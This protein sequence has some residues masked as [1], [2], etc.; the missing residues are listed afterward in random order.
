MGTSADISGGQSR[1]QDE[2]GLAFEMVT[3]QS[4][5]PLRLDSGEDLYP[6]VQAYNTYGSLNAD[7]TNA[8]LV[9]HA[10]TLDQHAA[11][12][13]PATGKE[14]WWQGMIGPGRPID[15]DRFFVICPNV[16]GGCQG[17]TGPESINSETGK[18]YGLN[19]PGDRKSTRLNSSH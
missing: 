18:P 2:Q 17:T 4:D 6:V 12:V 9:C 1:S 13:H 14:G 8:V 19:F 5:Q 7:K 11:N 15:T 16:V 3:F 10:L